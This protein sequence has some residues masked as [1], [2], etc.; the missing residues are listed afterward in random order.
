MTD[1]KQLELGAIRET[2]YARAVEQAVHFAENGQTPILA[3]RSVNMTWANE[4]PT[5]DD[6]I[7]VL[8]YSWRRRCSSMPNSAF[9]VHHPAVRPGKSAIDEPQQRRSQPPSGAARRAIKCMQ[10]ECQNEF[11]STGPE[12]RH[13]PSCRKK[14]NRKSRALG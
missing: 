13:C 5:W 7:Y 12:N 6:A 4:H 11:V 2:S 10:H 1:R 8:A 14:I 3:I 9:D